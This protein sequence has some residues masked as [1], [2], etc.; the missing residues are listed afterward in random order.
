MTYAA[1]QTIV[2]QRL[3]EGAGAVFY[4]LSEIGAAL[5]EGQRLFVFLTLCIERTADWTIA[6]GA[7]FTHMRTPFPDWI[8]PL[9]LT[10]ANGSKIRPVRL[11]DL[12][13]LDSQW[14]TASGPAKRYVAMGSDLVALYPTP[15]E[16]T[17]IP[18]QYAALPQ[19]LV[20]AGD[21]PE[22]AAQNHPVLVSYAIYRCRMVEGAQEFEKTLELFD[23]FIAAATQY[24]AYVRARNQGANFDTLPPEISSM[25][26]SSLVP[27]E[28]AARR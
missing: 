12:W 1:M 14:P 5:N 18:A 13:A 8:A 15:D 28:R 6:P 26:R 23:E 9:R 17:T 11:S 22:I 7:T 24:A 3:N 20:N 4:P 2:S 25:D 16:D 27:V 10:A 19:A 21:V